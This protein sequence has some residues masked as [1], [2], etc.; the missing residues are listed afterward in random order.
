MLLV[1]PEYQLTDLIADFS[2]EHLFIDHLEAVF[3]EK[4]EWDGDEKYKPSGLTIYFETTS[5]AGKVCLSKVKPEMH[6]KNILSHKSYTVRDRIPGFFIV[7]TNSNF[8]K[9]FLQSYKNL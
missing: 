9:E 5:S 4:P 1:Y 8:E 7:P 6:L 3:E 2:E